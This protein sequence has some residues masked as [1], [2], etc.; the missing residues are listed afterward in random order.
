MKVYAGETK[1]DKSRSHADT[2]KKSS[3]Y[4]TVQLINN[5]PK[6]IAQ[7]KLQL[8]VNES[9]QVKQLRALQ[10]MADNRQAKQTAPL[11]TTAGNNA[12]QPVQLLVNPLSYIN[13]DTTK[14]TDFN[15]TANHLTSSDAFTTT[16]A[17]RRANLRTDP[18]SGSKNTIINM[19]GLSA[20]AELGRM[21]KDPLC[22]MGEIHANIGSTIIKPTVNEYE[23]ITSTK[24]AD[25]TRQVLEG[26]EDQLNVGLKIIDSPTPKPGK[27]KEAPKVQIFHLESATLADN[28]GWIT[29]KEAGEAAAAREKAEREADAFAKSVFLPEEKWNSSLVRFTQ[30]TDQIVQFARENRLS[31]AIIA[32]WIRRERNDYTIFKELVGHGKV[33]KS[34]KE[35]GLLETSNVTGV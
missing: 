6:A 33:R 19:T 20:Q 22:P 26:G 30:S 24:N 9:S 12:A 27:S 1:E 14:L 13:K 16:E 5:S 28:A 3:S 35:A 34:L 21:L 11:Q 4:T 17:K 31:P 2:Q 29:T 25:P 23:W 18:R 10:Q 32:G 8:M 7:R 15:F